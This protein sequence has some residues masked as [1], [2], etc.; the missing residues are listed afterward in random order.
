MPDSLRSSTR[1]TT[2]TNLRRDHVFVVGC[3]RRAYGHRRSASSLG[4]APVRGDVSRRIQVRVLRILALLASKHAAARSVLS[5]CVP[6]G[7]ASLRRVPR[8]HK[9]HGHA[10]L[11]RLVGQHVLLPSERPGVHPAASILA[12]ALRSLSDVRQI[13]EGQRGATGQRIEDVLGDVMVTPAPKPL[14]LPRA[15]LEAALGGL[16][17]FGLEAALR[18]EVTTVH[19][20][21][22]GVA[23][24]LAVGQGSRNHNA[25]ITTD[26]VG[27]RSGCFH[28]LGEREGQPPA[29]LGIARELAGIGGPGIVVGDAAVFEDGD[30]ETLAHRG[31]GDLLAVEAHGHGPGVIGDGEAVAARTR[32]GLALLLAL[33]E[34]GH[35][36]HGEALGV[37]NELGFEAVL[38]D[39]VAVDGV[40]ELDGAFDVGVVPGVGGGVVVGSGDAGL[41]VEEAGCRVLRHVYLHL[42]RP[43]QL[44]VHVGTK[45][46]FK[47][48]VQG[49]APPRRERRC[50]RS[51]AQE[52]KG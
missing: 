37:A 17:A 27:G 13:F 48:Q 35:G 42:D 51:L 29:A 23:E 40:V 38:G 49:G 18:A 9:H 15:Q 41:E 12:E 19:M 11:R 14:P 43:R 24:D 45:R 7:G 47:C 50:L 28:L 22:V 20:M 4:G 6:T 32:D 25:S 33:A 21:P 26:D 5:R 52:M 34:R 44:H 36:A 10:V 39:E 31:Q 8:I 3:I 16:G 2:A 30:R 1:N 46:N